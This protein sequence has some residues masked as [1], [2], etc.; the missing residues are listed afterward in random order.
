MNQG[1]TQMNTP[2]Q[3]RPMSSSAARNAN[4]LKDDIR[5]T[6][7]RIRNLTRQGDTQLAQALSWSVNRMRDQLA[8]AETQ[9][10]SKAERLKK[11]LG[12]VSLAGSTL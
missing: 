8:V 4:E 12:Y 2:Y 7:A 3:L 10:G 11:R 5:A 9:M 6:M 1:E